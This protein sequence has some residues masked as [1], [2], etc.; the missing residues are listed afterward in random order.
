MLLR[1]QAI[2]KSFGPVRVLNGADLQVNEG[3]RIGL[4]GLNGAG[5]STF[6]KIL[7]GEIKPDTGELTRSTDRIGYLEQFA[8]SSS[9]VTVRDVLN[10]PYGHVESI[11]ARMRE[12]DDLMASGQDIDWNATAGEYSELEAQIS[13]FNVQSED[14]LI[15]SLGKVGLSKEFMD[16]TMDSL[17]G[18]ERTKI[19]ISR[20]LVQADEC[21]M[22]IMDEPTSHL[23]ITTVEWLED[24]LIK[25]RC[26]VLV[27]SHDRYFLDRVALRTVEI[28]GM[29][30]REY[31][32]NYTTF[33]E[34]KTLDLERMEKEYNKYSSKKKH[35]EEIVEQMIRDCKYIATHKTRE[36]MIA[37]MEEKEKPDD[38]KAIAVKMQ[39]VQKSGK[40]VFLA[41]NLSVGYGDEMVL[42]NVEIDIQK[43]DKVGVFGGNGE[44]KSTLIKA[45]LGKIPTKGELWLAPG[46]KLGYYSQH[47]EGLDLMLT[48][49]EQLIRV[50]GADRRGDARAMLSKLL[51]V[52]DDV[53]KPMSTMSGGQR[54][55]V[56]LSL[57]LLNGTNLL[58]LDEPT[59]YLD[60]PAK[61]AMEGAL[62][63][64]DG[65]VIVITHDR[66]FLDNVCTKVIEVKNHTAITYA[67][68]YS[69]MK[70]REE[71][72]EVMVEAEEFRVLQPFTE[73]VTRRKFVKGD[74]VL[75]TPD[76]MKNYQ[77]ALDQDKLKSTGNHKRIPVSEESAPE[78]PAF[79][80]H[81]AGSQ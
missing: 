33:V 53:E 5:K 7:L 30:T 16:R 47:H 23:D 73:W 40:N 58:I 14:K 38:V 24:Y 2:T 77:S 65:T 80:I 71:P 69:E 54:A 9:T 8:E 64:Y 26:A 31:K 78:D 4:I 41:H 45:L 36:K 51:L 22:L 1:A 32:G 39:S 52:G 3:D 75:I 79:T 34:K 63:E 20:I 29:K 68:T 60:I 12:L 44:G 67:G 42:E 11:E 27:I 59:N 62:E 70:I 18:G 25:T 50:V 56:A 17:S 81:R 37:K 55:K 6:L 28:S 46:A 15:R 61:N 74:K 48:A 10:R 72:K 57:L 49:E 13:K 35:Q 21:D 66:Y 43:G 19:M 76:A